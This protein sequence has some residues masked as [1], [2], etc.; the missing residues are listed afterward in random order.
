MISNKII[1]IFLLSIITSGLMA[2]PL[3]G[4]VVTPSLNIVSKPIMPA[5]SSWLNLN[6]IGG[7]YSDGNG[8]RTLDDNEIYDLEVSGSS[9]IVTLSMG[10]V[11]IDAYANEARYDT[12]DDAD[13]TFDG[14]YLKNY[15]ETYASLSLTGQGNVTVG[16]AIHEVK[17]NVFV[18]LP[19]HEDIDIDQS[20]IVGSF[21]IK[22]FESLFIGGGVER[23]NE[24]SSL[25]VDN[26]W[27]EATGGIALW[28]GQNTD[29]QFRL[30]ASNTDSPKAK[31]ETDLSSTKLSA[32][33][34]HSRINRINVDLMM[35]G[36]L[37][38]YSNFNQ[39]TDKEITNSSTGETVDQIETSISEGSV[40][41][42]PQEGLI[43]GFAFRTFKYKEVFEDNVDSFKVNLGFIF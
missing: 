29:T 5:A 1:R 18:A 27:T 37:F 42:I 35:N 36:L 31:S 21:S 8:K 14:A 23:I 24:T 11:D 7:E 12:K 17:R 41:W 33:H 3:T 22:I 4:Q 30:E 32:V 10:N 43:L 13:A 34:P 40:Q 39:I 20:G 26:S 15:S 38:S 2:F 25:T 19:D 6:S 9:G 16:A 28:F